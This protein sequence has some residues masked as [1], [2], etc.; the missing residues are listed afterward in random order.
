MSDMHAYVYLMVAI[1]AEVVAT[2]ALKAS[3]GFTKLAPSMIVVAG[4]GASF[5]MLSLTLRTLPIGVS[6]ALWSG[7]GII[8][9]TITGWVLYNQKIDLAGAIGMA[10]IVTGVIVLNFFSES[11]SH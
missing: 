3:H 8:L 11:A 2:S 6:Y 10:L 7:I 5:F 9:I 4:Y 1:V